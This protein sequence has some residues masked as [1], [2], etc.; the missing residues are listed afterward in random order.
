MTTYRFFAT[1]PKH[2]EPIL[3]DEL[4]YLG[5]PGVTV[6]RG[7]VTFT[8]N[9]SDA[10][11]ACLWSRTANNVLLELASFP[12]ESP[13]ALYN[14]M[15]NIDWNEHFS[16]DQTFAVKV[17]LSHSNITHSHFAALKAKDAIVDQFRDR[18]GER[19]SVNTDQPDITLN[20]YIRK[21]QATLSLDLSGESLHKRGYRLEGAFAPLKENLAAAILL[22]AGWPDIEKSGGAFVDPMCGSGT[23]P[24]EAAMIAIQQAPGIL[25]QHWGFTAWKK[26]DS[27]SWQSLIQQAEEQRQSGIDKFDGSIRG[28][29][30]N[31]RA[32]R[33]ALN[34][35]ERAGLNGIVHVEKQALSSCKPLSTN[36][37]NGL[38]LVN[39]PYGER[40]GE[41]NELRP[42]YMALGEQLKQ[43]FVGWRAGILTGN[44][45]LIKSI[46]IRYTRSNKFFNG[47]I[48]CELFH[49]NITPD[50]FTSANPQPKPL[51]ADERSENAV[52]FANRLQK[53]KK[54]LSR[55]LKREDIH[56]YRIYDADL[57]EY[58][59][60][61]DVY[62]GE[63]CWVHVQEYEAP[64][65]VDKQKAR[66]RLREAL[67]VILDVMEINRDQLFFK[68]RRQQKGS[69]QYEKLGDT[70]RFFAVEENG[71]KFLVN[72]EDYLDTGLFL[73]HRI[74][75][76]MI[77]EAAKNKDFLN[78]FAYTG[79]A[80]VYAATSGAKSTTTVDMSKTYLDWAQK[81][82]ELNHCTGKQ[83]ELVQANCIDWLKEAA[84]KGRRFD[85]IFLDP[86][87]FSSSKRM[88]STFDV[89]RD[90]VDLLKS[91]LK[92]LNPQGT[93]IFST[94]LRRFKLD[95]QALSNY[96]LKNI[97]R[98]TLPK[99]FERNQKIHQCWEIRL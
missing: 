85:L 7:G 88:Q 80:T 23:L 28:Y 76:N 21:N 84:K 97:S 58:A 61:V 47:P 57:P 51:A 55:W 94:N 32:I 12:A 26:H 67:G 74:T 65:N 33:V 40:L 3:A 68:V 81:N 49:Y 92:L 66:T 42:L 35:I 44:I 73:D 54:T 82:L 52:M 62:E 69:A 71:R 78:L 99:D 25:R 4:T 60:A 2:I 50:A 15:A 31:I 29:D 14:G 90:H 24:I 19:P 83:H 36:T 64:K 93:L 10:Y 48:P 39:P 37:H 34:N 17:N 91:T 1:A 87:S 96:Q 63:K 22:R 98:A 53:N 20:L 86:P 16:P 95:E 11:R 43:Q 70:K 75:R 9:L 18:F 56:C 59:V 6:T 46:G 13:E 72:F 38:V 89:Q 77:G 8:G 41:K 45:E 5:V 27:A 79:S 30:E